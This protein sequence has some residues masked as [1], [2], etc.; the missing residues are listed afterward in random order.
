MFLFLARWDHRDLK[1]Y[2]DL[3]DLQEKTGFRVLKAIEAHLAK[4]A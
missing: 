4:T 1:G 2:L 3:K